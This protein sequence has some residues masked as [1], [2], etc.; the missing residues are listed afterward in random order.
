MKFILLST[1]VAGL[2]LVK[3]ECPV[4]ND[5][6]FHLKVGGGSH[7]DGQYV[8]P[9]ETDMDDQLVFI[10]AN[11]DCPWSLGQGTLDYHMNGGAIWGADLRKVNDND[12]VQRAML[13]KNGGQQKYYYFDGEQLVVNSTNNWWACYTGASPPGTDLPVLYAYENGHDGT[14]GCFK[15]EL[16]REW[17]R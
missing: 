5:D 10:D 1:L 9:M 2:G 14:E 12:Q 3:A 15:V 17:A 7:L 6:Q 16:N 13:I 4:T 8:R 11:F